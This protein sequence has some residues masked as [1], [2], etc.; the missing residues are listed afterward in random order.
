MVIH[1]FIMNVNF[2]KFV[3]NDDAYGDDND[4]NMNMKMKTY[5]VILKNGT[6]S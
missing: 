5:V 2:N 1:E 4:M 3:V 6:K